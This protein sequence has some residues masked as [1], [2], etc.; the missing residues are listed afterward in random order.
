MSGGARDVR[1]PEIVAPERQ[2]LADGLGERKDEDIAESEAGRVAR[3]ES[4]A[5]PVRGVA[6]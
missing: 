6:A 2:R 4:A 5:A 3:P 1:V